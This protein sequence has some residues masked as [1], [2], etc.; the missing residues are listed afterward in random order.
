MYDTF[1]DTIR[2]IDELAAHLRVSRA[3]IV[4]E[5]K[6][7][8]LRAFLFHDRYRL[9]PEDMRA[10]LALSATKKEAVAA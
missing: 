2:T 4:N 6:R 1:F 7:R 9:L 8:N 10:W 3:L 5:I